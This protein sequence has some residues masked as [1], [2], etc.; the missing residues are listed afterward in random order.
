VRGASKDGTFSMPVNSAGSEWM[1]A[2]ARI[3]LVKSSDSAEGLENKDCSWVQ[4]LSS[5]RFE[6]MQR[7]ASKALEIQAKVPIA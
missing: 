1:F 6:A 7:A 4:W 2:G 3:A 5:S